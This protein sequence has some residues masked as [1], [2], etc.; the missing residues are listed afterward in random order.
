[1]KHII[2]KSLYRIFIVLLF[3][4]NFHPDIS[5]QNNSIIFIQGNDTAIVEEIHIKGGIKEIKRVAE[6]I[7][8]RASSRKKWAVNKTGNELISE[9]LIY[10]NRDFF[11]IKD[12]LI[13]AQDLLLAKQVNFR[14][15][16]SYK[17]DLFYKN[18]FDTLI[19]LLFTNYLRSEERRVGQDCRS[20]WSADN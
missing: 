12:S 16:Y 6:G 14:T 17:N 19:S 18:D 15:A 13:L 3:I 4:L 5:S 20:R 11:D 2:L 8:F 7:S 1:M 9:G 10:P